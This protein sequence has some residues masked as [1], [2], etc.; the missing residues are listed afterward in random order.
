MIRQERTRG[1]NG[2]PTRIEH[3]EARNAEAVRRH[4]TLELERQLNDR[5]LKALA[6]VAPAAA[7]SGS[8][9]QIVAFMKREAAEHAAEGNAPHVEMDFAAGTVA[10][11]PG[12]IKYTRTELLKHV[13]AACPNLFF[14]GLDLGQFQLEFFQQFLDFEFLGLLGDRGE[15]GFW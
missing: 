15:N 4:V 9:K 10:G 3:A 12:G 8:R 6:G 5:E 13:R 1:P 14:G 7:S 2:E 11:F